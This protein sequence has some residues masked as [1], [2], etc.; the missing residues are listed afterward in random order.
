VIPANLPTVTVST[1]ELRSAWATI[2]AGRTPF[3]RRH[4]D[5]ISMEPQYRDTSG[6][7]WIGVAGPE[8]S[9]MLDEGYEPEGESPLDL[10]GVAEISSPYM[11]LAEEDGDLMIEAA[12]GGDDLPYVRWE[13]FEA[14][15]GLTIRAV[16]E[17]NA[18]TPAKV[19]SGYFAWILKLIDAAERQGLAPQVELVGGVKGAVDREFLISI[20][21]VK[22]GELVDP[23]AWRAF[24]H[25]GGYRTLG[26][27]SMALAAEKTGQTLRSG[28]GS[29][30]GTRWDARF[31]DDVL[32][33][34]CPAHSRD[35]PEAEMTAKAAEAVEI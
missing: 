8:M 21:L 34:E 11:D 23:V 22:A 4:P 18:G 2:Q 28:L 27:V 17:F 29:A 6:D 33:I 24:F 16:W 14:K 12:L 19:I 10:S 30:F 35:F 1:T 32:T 3:G 5:M 20:P 26:F 9:R 13:D 7:G 31:A 25:G 15:R